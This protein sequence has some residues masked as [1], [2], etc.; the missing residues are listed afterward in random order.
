[1]YRAR[2]AAGRARAI[3]SSDMD[4]ERVIYPLLKYVVMGPAMRVAFLPG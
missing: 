2:A 1:M 3:A 4:P